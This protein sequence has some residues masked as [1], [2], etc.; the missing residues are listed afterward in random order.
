[1]ELLARGKLNLTLDVCG[2]R[3][4]GYHDL[5]MLMQT[6][7]LSDALTVTPGENGIKVWTNLRFIPSDGRNLAA[8]AAQKFCEENGLP[9]PNLSLR[10]E[11]HIPVCAG[12]A[13]GSTDAAAVLHAMNELTGLGLS[14][15]KLRE[16]GLKIG[17]DVPYCIIGGTMLA[18]GRGEL[19]T[20]VSPIPHCFVTLCKPR[21][22]IKTPELF[23][24]IDGHKIARRPDTE[25]A[26][27]ALRAGDLS[28]LA[29]RMYNV[30]E[31][32]LPP[33]RRREIDSIK[34]ILV[35]CGALGA[36]M[37]GTGPTVFGLFE[38]LADAQE[39]ARRLRETYRDVFCTETV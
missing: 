23:A 19:L 24:R 22:G 21:F 27:A 16:I 35:A 10:I 36:T 14:E 1:M 20:A 12:M 3:P 13:G 11:K 18:E 7:A 26:L 8:I 5:Q 32:V 4:D 38:Q 2:K 30:F 34:N 17:A 31:D 29:R 39:G 28:G 6:V 37:T 33:H 9:A 15:E 25:G